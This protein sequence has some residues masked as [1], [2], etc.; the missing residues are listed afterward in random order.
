[1]AIVASIALIVRSSDYVRQAKFRLA[2][3][4]LVVHRLLNEQFVQT[5][6]S[7]SVFLEHI[8]WVDINDIL[9]VIFI[10]NCET[11]YRF[12]NC[13]PHVGGVGGLQQNVKS[14]LASQF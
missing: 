13:A 4:W 10:G 14:V 7:A 8:H 6:I 2:P 11:F 5:M 12:S 1:L 9:N 3:N